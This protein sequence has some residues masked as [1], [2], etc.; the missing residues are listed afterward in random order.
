MAKYKSP[1]P[2]SGSVGGATFADNHGAPTV[3]LRAGMSKRKW[4]TSKKMQP[5]RN[6]SHAFGAASRLAAQ[7]HRQLR[8]DM[9][10]LLGAHYHNRITAAI[11]HGAPRLEFN[12]AP[13]LPAVLSAIALRQLDLGHL[14]KNGQPP[15]VSTQHHTLTQRVTLHGLRKQL[16]TIPLKPGEL[17]DYRILTAQVAIPGATA[18]PNNPGAFIPEPDAPDFHPIHYTGEWTAAHTLPDTITIPAPHHDNTL[19]IVGIQWRVVRGLRIRYLPQHNIL[20]VAA[21]HPGTRPQD[22]PWL[23]NP[24][25]RKKKKAA[26][27]PSHLRNL[28]T[29][30]TPKEAKAIRLRHLQPHLTLHPPIPTP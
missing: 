26:P 12:R 23:R 21:A 13:A 14:P 30:L 27:T 10:P 24:K 7:I 17:L 25:K 29:S 22:L 6:Q 16:A 5:A 11:L 20:R 2:L 18:D 8:P 1:F 15:I 28:P 4:K 9:R 3:R 19:L